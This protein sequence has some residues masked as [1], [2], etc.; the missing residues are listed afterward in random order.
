VEIVNSGAL[1]EGVIASVDLEEPNGIITSA[2]SG[3]GN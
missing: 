2:E 3:D 1:A